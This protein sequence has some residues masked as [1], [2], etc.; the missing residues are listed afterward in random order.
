MGIVRSNNTPTDALV[1]IWHPEPGLLQ[2]A[3]SAG[4]DAVYSPDGPWYLNWAESTWEVMYSVEPTHG[5]APAPGRVIGG[6][7]ELWG[8]F[9]DPSDIESTAWPR[10]AAI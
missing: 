9:V 5:L 8:E 6:G 2:K 4:H 1:Q 3:I 7:G 10:L